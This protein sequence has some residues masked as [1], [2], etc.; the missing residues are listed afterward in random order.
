[1]LKG[2]KRSQG[3]LKMLG[4]GWGG[5]REA[6]RAPEWDGV[7]FKRATLRGGHEDHVCIP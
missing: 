3:L 2:D 6:P 7:G 1:M 4:Q 5:D